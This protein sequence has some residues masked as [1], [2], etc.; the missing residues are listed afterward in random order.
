MTMTFHEKGKKNF[1][2]NAHHTTLSVR[3]MT[4]LLQ[5][6][7]NEISLVYWCCIAKTLRDHMEY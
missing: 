6:K 2:Q 3:P 4:L 1:S 7:T 5:P